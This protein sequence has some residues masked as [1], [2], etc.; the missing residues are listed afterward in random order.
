LGVVAQVARFVDHGAADAL[1]HQPAKHARKR[2]ALLMEP[3]RV[4]SIAWGALIMVSPL[5]SNSS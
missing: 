4:C 5:P 1:V 3:L 2:S